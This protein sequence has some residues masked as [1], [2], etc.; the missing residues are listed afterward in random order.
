MTAENS[1]FGRADD[2][3]TMRSEV[4]VSER[5]DG[6]EFADGLL[7]VVKNNVVP[8]GETDCDCVSERRGGDIQ[9]LV[10][11][12]N[13]P[14]HFPLS[15]N[16]SGASSAELDYATDGS[17]SPGDRGTGLHRKWICTQDAIAA[18]K[19]QSA[20]FSH[21][22]DIAR[23][24]VDVDAC[25]CGACSVRPAGHRVTLAS[26]VLAPVCRGGAH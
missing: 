15:G 3:R 20:I 12:I 18:K 11:A 16:P 1:G 2:D 23:F 13:G 5:S 9:D 7:F 22:G 14:S 19:V 24:K 10:V 25:W 8:V 17:I 4:Q 26:A 21:H 6:C